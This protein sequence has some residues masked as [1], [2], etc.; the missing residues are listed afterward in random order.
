VI[1]VLFINPHRPPH[2]AKRIICNANLK[3]LGAGLAIYAEK[4]GNRYPTP[5]QWC[6]LLVAEYGQAEDFNDI[7][8]CRGAETGPCNYAIN[9][10]ADPNSADDVVLL[11]ESKPGWNQFGGMELLTL[12]NHE[13]QGCNILLVDGNVEF[14]KA[15]EIVG[16]NWVDDEDLP[17]E[18]RNARRPGDDE[19]LKY[20]LENMIWYH[21]F[22]TEEVR[23]ATGLSEKEIVAAQERFDIRP[24]GR[25]EREPN[26]PLLVLP[27]PGG[28]HPRIGFLEGAIDPQRETKF[29]VFTPWDPNSYAVLDI[30]EALWSNLGLTY[31]AHTHIDTIWTQQGIELEK[32]EWRRHPD[33]SLD[34]KRILPNGLAFGVEVRPAPD[35]VHMEMW[36]SNG[37][38][39]KLT[40]LRVQNCVMPKMAAGFA[41]QT[42]DNKVLTDPYVACRNEDGT[43]WIITAWESCDRPW[44]NPDCPCFHSDPK[45]PDLEP[46]QTHRLRGWFS[47]YEGEDIQAEFKRIEATGWRQN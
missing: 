12:E 10:N 26:A 1:L 32:L 37:T 42:N 14:V 31:L 2:I 38:K 36:L 41:T 11:F 43:R 18:V 27:Y 30:P 25:P 8:R 35:A 46:G 29:S 13:G 20:W 45:F 9:P 16:L 17:E 28:R 44:A 5:Q 22:S 24:G 7:F 21:R 47:F 15:D 19:E 34:F 4:Y 40:D 6:D 39:Q 3:Q 23:A 33:G